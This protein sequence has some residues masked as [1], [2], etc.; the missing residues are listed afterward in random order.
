MPFRLISSG[1]WAQQ[2]LAPFFLANPRSLPASDYLRLKFPL[3][4]VTGDFKNSSKFGKASELP[5]TRV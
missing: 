4:C 5:L 2:L 1:D 3:P